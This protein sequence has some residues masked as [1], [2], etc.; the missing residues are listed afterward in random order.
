M[1]RNVEPGERLLAAL[2]RELTI[3]VVEDHAGARDVT[4]LL[5][6]SLGARVAVAVDGRDAL[7]LLPH[8]RPDLVLTDLA[9]PRIGGRELLDRLRAD[10]AHRS[11]PVVAV[12]GLPASFESDK[13]AFD[14][15]LDK[16]FDVQSLAAVL[17]QVIC[18]HRP[19]FLR[20]QR[21]LCHEASQQRRHS[22]ELR[23]LGARAVK[24]A[25]EA[26]ARGRALLWVAA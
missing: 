19:M 25:E 1:A 10:P 16:P 23:Q 3:L 18:R 2:L 11:L 21:R 6:E 15:Q 13:A 20:Q 4:Q 22:R 17:C 24:R 9:M 14:G 5:L 12:S 7:D 8:V 26:R